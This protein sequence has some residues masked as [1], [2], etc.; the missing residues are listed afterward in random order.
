MP[1][2]V[3]PGTF[4]LDPTAS[5]VEVR[6]KTMWGLVTVKGAFAS[7]AGKGEVHPDGTASGTVTLDARSLDT[8]NAKRD[9]HLRS[10]HFFAA[11][12]FPDLT[13]DVKA[14]SPRGDGNTVTVEGTLT[15]R[16]I[17]RPQPV[18]ATVTGSDPRSVS[19][20]TEFTVDRAD[21]GM[22]FNQMGMVRGQ[23]TIRATLRFVRADG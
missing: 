17:T 20:T 15:V 16:D 9:T 8:G 13:F 4:L 23:A 22:T 10:D 19:L 6:H 18:S 11:D 1:S 5:T 7:V 12:S 3:D 2:T 21:F 14:A